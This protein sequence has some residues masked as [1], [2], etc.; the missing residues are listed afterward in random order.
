MP[1]LKPVD[2]V[3]RADNWP[4]T[5]N[6]FDSRSRNIPAPAGSRYFFRLC[7]GR[8]TPLLT[9]Y[10]EAANTAPSAIFA[11]ADAIALKIDIQ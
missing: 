8:F 3:D 5:R 10:T 11:A 4:K 1:V 9:K 6:A 2:K 7:I